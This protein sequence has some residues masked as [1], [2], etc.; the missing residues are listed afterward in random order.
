MEKEDNPNSIKFLTEVYKNIKPGIYET[1]DFANFL[2]S[3]EKYKEAINLYSEILISID[4]EQNYI[5]RS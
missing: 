5:L 1:F 3:N 2:R 4:Q